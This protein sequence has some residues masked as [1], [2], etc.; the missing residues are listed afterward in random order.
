MN[1]RLGGKQSV[2]PAELNKSFTFML[3][4]LL[5]D[6][7]FS[8]RKNG[9]LK[10][11]LPECQQFFKFYFTRDRGLPGNLYSLTANLSF[12][13]PE[14]DRLTCDFLGEG[15][16]ERARQFHTGAEPLYEVVPDRLPTQYKYCADESIYGLAERVS[17]DF[18]AYAL[19]FYEKYDTLEKLE[20]YFERRFHGGKRSF[21][22]IREGKKPGSGQ[23]CC[24]AAVLYLL[25]KTGKLE[26]FFKETDLLTDEY[27]ERI[28]KY[29]L[30]NNHE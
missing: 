21:R 17:E 2:M 20:N 18:H 19:P 6:T 30:N 3:N 16:D 27:R 22:V 7:D 13:F 10:R 12:S 15:Y 29:I 23:G 25:G 24:Y 4:E 9:C 8:K 26:K 5:A 28:S 14:L 11:Q 1:S